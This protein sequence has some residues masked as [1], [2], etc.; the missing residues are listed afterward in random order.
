LEFLYGNVF[1]NELPPHKILRLYEVCRR[2]EMTELEQMC[3]NR[4]LNYLSL[5]NVFDILVEA[6]ELNVSEMV[7]V[8]IWYAST[9]ALHPPQKVLARI[10][11]DIETISKLVSEL[12]T[13]SMAPP[14]RF[15]VQVKP[16][17]KFLEN[18][19]TSKVNS[20]F[21]ICINNV[22]IQVHKCLLAKWP[23]F[24]RILSKETKHK[25]KIPVSTFKKLLKYMYT[26]DIKELTLTDCGWL[27][28][29]GD[30]YGLD[31]NLLK[32]CDLVVNT[33]INSNN[34]L[35]ALKLSLSLNNKSLMDR[36][37]A[38]IPSSIDPN[39]VNFFLGTIDDLKTSILQY[40]TTVAQ[41][42]A[43]LAQH[44]YRLGK[45]EEMLKNNKH[46]NL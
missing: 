11:N 26:C 46:Q 9:H 15:N 40:E 4:I 2:F 12:V 23:F 28:S 37:L 30:Y 31:E 22:T 17:G 35:E 29:Y 6:C 7:D 45:I 32:F 27:L 13:L 5:D 24:V 44:E 8:A 16:L 42:E 1:H 20:D 41:L 36:A 34:W 18:L 10:Q 3:H 38:C 43:A 21:E 19:F 14:P 39:L 33:E 25:T